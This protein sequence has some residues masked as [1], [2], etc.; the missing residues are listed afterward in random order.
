MPSPYLHGGVLEGAGAIHLEALEGLVGDPPET[1]RGGGSGDCLGQWGID[2]ISEEYE[3]R[4]ERV[5]LERPMMT[6][7]ASDGDRMRPEC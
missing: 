3:Q 2:E 5:L 6:F 4:T 1:A 7:A